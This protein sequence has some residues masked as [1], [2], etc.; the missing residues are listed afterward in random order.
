VYLMYVDESGDCG[1]VDSPTRYFVLSGLVVH[2]LR[3]KLCLD[4]FVQFR[5]YLRDRFGLRLREEFHASAFLSKPGDLVRIKRHDRLAMIRAFADALAAISDANVINVVVDKEGKPAGYDV[6]DKAWAA[7]VQ[8]FENTLSGRNFLGPANPDERGFV[9]CDHTD[10]KKL[11][12]LLRRMRHYNPVPS[13]PEF[14]S[15]YRNLP[16]LSIIED[17]S[18]RDSA[19][20]YFVQAADLAAF[21]LYQ[22]L[23]PSRYMRRKS[24][25]NFFGRLRPILCL[26]ASRTDPDGVVRL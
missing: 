4:E 5:G 15:G 6:F 12:R 13:R 18:F 26:H 23:A 16:V 25:Q 7:L 24:G 21:L 19:H 1:L 20:S 9:L 22:R 3:W 11:V 14:G 8:R 2:E 17:P 10:D